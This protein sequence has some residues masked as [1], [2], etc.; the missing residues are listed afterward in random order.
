MLKYQYLLGLASELD[1]P[2]YGEPELGELG[3]AVGDVGEPGEEVTSVVDVF[4]DVVEYMLEEF[5]DVWQ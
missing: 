5:G 4:G 3:L 2:P 1:D